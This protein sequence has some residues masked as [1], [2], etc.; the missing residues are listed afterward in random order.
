MDRIDCMRAFV[1]TVRAN[2]FASA[3]RVLNVPRSKV[4]KQIQAL[5]E[6]LGVQ[7]LMRS[8]RSL[9]LTAAGAAYFDA[10][11]GVLS[12]LEEAEQR[13]REGVATLR[14][15][16]R[17]N[18]P[19]SFG[20]RVLGPLL[21]KFHAQH[22]D[23]ELQIAASDQLLDPIKGGFDVTIRIAALADSN[24]I[25]RPIIPAPRMLAAS[26]EYLQEHGTPETPEEL[27]RHAFLAYGNAVQEGVSLSLA[28]GADA[29]RVQVRG[30]AMADNGDLLA[31]LAEAGMGIA[32]LPTF[33][34][35]ESLR[36]G[37][38]VQI[39][40][41]WKAPPIAINAIYTNAQHVPQKTRRFIDF[42]IEE[43]RGGEAG[44]NT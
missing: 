4:S 9:H 34:V 12:A 23:V 21:P 5:E 31:L 36:A 17:V 30:P 7:L 18:A 33:I 29:R 6:M 43:L 42:L 27:E 8:T 1:E 11:R 24:L 20:V 25:A 10:A 35:D 14:G 15:V 28:K 39:L 19:V 13:A 22:P 38:L 40:P 16:L 32:L 44:L 2:G 26:P 41:E 3:A 37:R